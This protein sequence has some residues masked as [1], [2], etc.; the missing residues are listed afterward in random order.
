MI[1]PHQANS[2]IID[3]AARRAS[4]PREKFYVNIDRFGNTSSASIPIALDALN[5][6]GMLQSG[7]R[8]IL[9]AFGGGLANAACLIMWP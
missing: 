4:I 9:C 6:S 7:D 8:L 1:V 3:A 2:R 5:R